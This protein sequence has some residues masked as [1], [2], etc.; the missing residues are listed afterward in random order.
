MQKHFELL[1]YKV[2]DSVTGFTGVVTSISFELYGC[3]QALVHG[4]IDKDGKVIDQCWFDSKRLVKVGKI[5]VMEVPTFETV[6]GG[7]SLPKYSSTPVR[8]PIC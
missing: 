3:V 5:P 2:K 7:D 4:G 6:A 1:G 8:R